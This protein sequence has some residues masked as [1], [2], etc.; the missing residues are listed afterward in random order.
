ML[1]ERAKVVVLDVVCQII[2]ALMKLY[3]IIT[4]A[5]GFVVS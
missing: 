2:F 4:H 1:E 3:M 5:V